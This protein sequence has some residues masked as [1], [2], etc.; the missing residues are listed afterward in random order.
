VFTNFLKDLEKGLTPNPDILCNS[1]IKFR[2]FVEYAEKHFKPDFIATGHYAKIVRKKCECTTSLKCGHSR[3]FLAKPR[4]KAKDQT[5]F[6]CQINSP[7]L[8]KI[9]FPLADLTK[10]EVRQIAEEIKLI[11][12]KKKD[13]TGICFIGEQKFISF[14]SNYFPKK[15]GEII[16]V[17]SKKALGKHF[18][19]YYFTIGQRRNLSLSGQKNPYYVVGK[20][21]KKSII[22]VA[23][24]WNSDWLY[25]K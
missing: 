6:L 20:S 14:L 22:Y 11:N 5:Y 23:S 18:G 4:D 25:S 2:H 10:L 12:A 21:L 15:E 7:L 9:T 19:I 3:Y 17:E 13:S 8:S 16:D 24:G 1:V